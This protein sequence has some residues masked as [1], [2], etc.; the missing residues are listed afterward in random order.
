MAVKTSVKP[1]SHQQAVLEQAITGKKPTSDADFKELRALG[2]IE[3]NEL[4]Q[5]RLT[6]LGYHALND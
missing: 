3:G 2:Y 4:S 6:P 1:N 5:V